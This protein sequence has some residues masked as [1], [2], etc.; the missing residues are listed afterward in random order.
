ML[1]MIGKLFGLTTITVISLASSTP[2]HEKQGSGEI[3]I[4]NHF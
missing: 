4:L 3:Q 2:L 1:K